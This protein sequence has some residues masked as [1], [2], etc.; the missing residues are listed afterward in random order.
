M[1][2]WDELFLGTYNSVTV[3][4]YTGMQTIAIATSHRAQPQKPALYVTSSSVTHNNS[5]VALEYS[6]AAHTLIAR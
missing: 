3:K 6:A 1:V 5:V 4:E 2:F